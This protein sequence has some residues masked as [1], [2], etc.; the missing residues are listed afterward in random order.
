MT[1]QGVSC[2]EARGCEDHLLFKRDNACAWLL[3]G[4][5]TA[6]SINAILVVVSESGDGRQKQQI[7][8]CASDWKGGGHTGEKGRNVEKRT[9]KWLATR[10]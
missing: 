4:A 5:G 1:A 8:K 2:L 6:G 10:L 9:G 7:K 3:R